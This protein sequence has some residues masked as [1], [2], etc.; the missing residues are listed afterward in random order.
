MEVTDAHIA[1]VQARRWRALAA[2][3]RSDAETFERVALKFE[4][5]GLASS[6]ARPSWPH[7][8]DAYGAAADV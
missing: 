4:Q 7:T 1:L 8:P 5:K 6:G 3:A 2:K